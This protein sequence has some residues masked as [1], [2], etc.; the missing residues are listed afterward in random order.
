[1]LLLLLFEMSSYVS[2]FQV[3]DLDVEIIDLTQDSDHEVIQLFFE[4]KEDSDTDVSIVPAIY[5]YMNLYEIYFLPQYE[6][7]HLFNHVFNNFAFPNYLLRQVLGWV[8]LSAGFNLADFLVV[9]YWWAEHTTQCNWFNDQ[10]AMYTMRASI[11]R[12]PGYWSLNHYTRWLQIV[13]IVKSLEAN[14]STFGF[15]GSFTYE[16]VE[17]DNVIVID[18][19]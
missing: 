8:D 9:Q 4:E 5:G 13:T 12:W 14:H 16:F 19:D 7:P 1:M 18:D 11:D 3:M 2:N 17:W 15:F 6:G 10:V